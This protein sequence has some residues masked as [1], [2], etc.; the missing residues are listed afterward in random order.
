MNLFH[1]SLIDA[2]ASP[3]AT[4]IQ[5]TPMRAYRRIHCA[6]LLGCIALMAC[7]FS[8]QQRCLS[9]EL[10]LPAVERNPARIETKEIDRPIR[11]E[12]NLAFRQTEGEPVLADMF[13][14]DDERVC[15]LVLVIHGGAWSSG[16]K[17]QVADHARELAQAG[18]VSVAINYRLAPM[19]QLSEQI[20]DCRAALRWAES[21]ADAW[22]ADSQRICLWGYS[23]GGHLAALLAT[24]TQ[25]DDPAICA[26]VAGGAPC[27]F[28]FIPQESIALAHVLG[29]TRQQLPEDYRQASPLTHANPHAP[30]FFFFH[31]QTDAIVPS[32]SSRR[33]YDRLCELGA[34]A[35]Y[36]LVANRG[37]LLTFIDF[38]ARRLA[39]EFLRTHTSESP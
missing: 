10:S 21:Q 11:S 8:P 23:A 32:S 19:H 34:Q 20:A 7:I 36:H 12:K 35:E 16:D 28:D 5:V 25:P 17:W 13:R 6:S 26:V 29:G 24:E 9:Q 37:H 22:H 15:P 14:P 3:F 38:E 18:F 30:P 27:D 33:M 31:G 4:D 1:S 39:I 2:G